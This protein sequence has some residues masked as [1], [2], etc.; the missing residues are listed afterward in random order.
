MKHR[1][2]LTP[3]TPR[4]IAMRVAEEEDKL[5]AKEHATYKS[6]AG[7]LWY[8]TKH[9]RPDLCNGVSESPK[10]MDRLAPIHPKE[11]YRIIIYMLETKSYGLNFYLKDVHESFKL[12]VTVIL[13]ETRK[14]EEESMVILYTSVDTNCMEKQRHE[15]C[16]TVYNRS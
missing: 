9:S 5:P 12:L 6:G 11:M 2:D 13:L 15:K 10:T 3:G 14:Q 8:L 1:L 16:S 4:F 7:I